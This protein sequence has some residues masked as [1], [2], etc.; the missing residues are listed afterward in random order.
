MRIRPSGDKSS[1]HYR[2]LLLKQTQRSIRLGK[3]RLMV[4]RRLAVL[5][6]ALLV[7]SDKRAE[8]GLAPFRFAVLAL[9][10]KLCLLRAI[11]L[12]LNLGELAME[13]VL[14]RF[15]GAKHRTNGVP[16]AS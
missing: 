11:E 16:G 9:G 2:L 4:V 1:V 3:K 7:F 15:K 6:N 13:P 10:A 12:L 14:F 8:L 5:F